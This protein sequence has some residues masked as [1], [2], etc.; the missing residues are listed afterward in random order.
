MDQFC[1]DFVL[2]VV[3]GGCWVVMYCICSNKCPGC[4]TKS[5]RVGTYS[6]RYFFARINPKKTNKQTKQNKKHK[7]TFRPSWLIDMGIWLI[8]LWL[9]ISKFDEWALI[10]AWAAIGR[11]TVYLWLNF[12][13]SVDFGYHSSIKLHVYLSCQLLNNS[14]VCALLL[15]WSWVQWL[16]DR[17]IAQPNMAAALWVEISTEGY[18]V[19]MEKLNVTFE[20]ENHQHLTHRYSHTA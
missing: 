16:A 5:L 3:F 19:W 15:L 17:L 4:L 14:T 6:F 12:T 8:I 11:N 7:C 13:T 2:V 10:G 1:F 20:Q 9:I 18:K